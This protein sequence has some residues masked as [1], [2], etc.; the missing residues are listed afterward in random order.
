VARSEAQTLA[1]GA[2]ITAIVATAA[3][4]VSYHYMR[5]PNDWVPRHFKP[6]VGRS[7]TVP[8]PDELEPKPSGGPFDGSIQWGTAPPL[9]VIGWEPGTVTQKFVDEMNKGLAKSQMALGPAHHIV[10]NGH[11]AELRAIPTH[12]LLLATWVCPETGRTFGLTIV[13][14]SSDPDDMDA[15]MSSVTAGVECHH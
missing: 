6:F 3:G 5:P 10:V 4:A 12:G 2:V 8:G 9:Q 11:P 1:I 13:A 7:L 14:P 15:W